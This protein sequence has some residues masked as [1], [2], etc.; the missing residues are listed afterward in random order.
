LLETALQ[1]AAFLPPEAGQHISSLNFDYFTTADN[2]GVTASTTD[3]IQTLS[4][5]LSG[6][7][8]SVVGEETGG[9][10]H[11]H[12]GLKNDVGSIFKKSGRNDSGEQTIR[13]GNR[14]SEQMMRAKLDLPSPEGP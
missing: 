1:L 13:K 6:V 14:K 7:G 4:R 12:L 2:V 10:F 3:A 5:A 8:R 11:A 9:L